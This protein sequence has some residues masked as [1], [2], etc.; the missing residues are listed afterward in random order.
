MT[1]SYNVLSCV[2]LID[3]VSVQKIWDV[4]AGV[5]LDTQSVAHRFGVAKKTPL[6]Q[7][8]STILNSE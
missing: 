1:D 5:W 2:C 8:H 3:K 7:V 6:A 4:F